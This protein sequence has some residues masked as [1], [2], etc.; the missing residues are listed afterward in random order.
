MMGEIGP[1]GR[2]KASFRI[3]LYWVER[4]GAV[5]QGINLRSPT[6]SSL[7]LHFGIL[8]TSRREIGQNRRQPEEV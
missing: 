3:K 8:G 4:V 1:L 5:S 7:V 2:D 6:N